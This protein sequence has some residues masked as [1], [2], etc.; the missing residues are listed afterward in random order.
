MLKALPERTSDR[1]LAAWLDDPVVK[2]YQQAMSG[3]P[4]R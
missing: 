3:P 2:G 4:R 1:E